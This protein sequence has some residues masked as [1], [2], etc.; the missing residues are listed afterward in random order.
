[1]KNLGSGMTA[2]CV[3][4]PRLQC[5]TQKKRLDG[6]KRKYVSKIIQKP[7]N[8][9]LEL[10]MFYRELLISK[11]IADMAILNHSKE[12]LDSRFAVVY[13]SCL[14]DKEVNKDQDFKQCELENDTDYLI[15]FSVN[16]GC[17]AEGLQIGDETP[18]YNKSDN[19]LYTGVIDSI[20][21]NNYLVKLK[22]LGGKVVEINK[23]LTVRT[24]GVLNTKRVIDT[25][26]S[27]VE[28]VRPSFK[29]ILESI[30]FLHSIGIAHLDI[31][32]DNLISDSG[33]TIRI[34][35]FGASLSLTG[36][37]ELFFKKLCKKMKT[38]KHADFTDKFKYGLLT[39]IAVHTPG[40]VS[41]EF[42]LC[43]EIL[44][45]KYLNRDKV[46]SKISK[47]SK[48]NLT[49]ADNEFFKSLV[50]HKQ[51]FLLDMFCGIDNNKPALFLS[52]VYS[53]G[54]VFKKIARDGKVKNKKLNDLIKKMREPVYTKRITIDECLEH[55]FFKDLN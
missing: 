20:K 7:G 26:F 5:R 45:N 37:N 1:M 17:K 44:G 40:Y 11:K 27:K 3:T 23:H 19:K 54:T 51:K 34:I 50:K 2:K 47:K 29:Y 55:P 13:E 8:D 30:R 14:L 15:L 53:L 48:V 21:D 33:G 12:W 25:F 41:P 35:D 16:G 36:K 22:D 10:D 43:T 28:R 31:K 49:K 38:S 42:Q 18:Y 46:S 9:H 4:T 32:R 39:K 6:P 52:D 24:C